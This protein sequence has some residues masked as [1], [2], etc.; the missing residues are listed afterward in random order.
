[1]LYTLTYTLMMHET[2]ILLVCTHLQHT[3]TLVN[4]L[5]QGKGSEFNLQVVAGRAFTHFASASR[6]ATG[7]N[8]HSPFGFLSGFGPALR[9]MRGDHSSLYTLNTLA[10]TTGNMQETLVNIRFVT[11]AHLAH[12]F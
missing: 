5:R 9:A 10:L 11:L 8:F 3:C 1:M 7:K 4:G 2:L 12:L 6:F